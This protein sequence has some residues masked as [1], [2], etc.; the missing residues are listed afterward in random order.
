MQIQTWY[1]IQVISSICYLFKFCNNYLAGIRTTCQ[2]IVKLFSLKILL[3][4]F[5][6]SEMKNLFFFTLL[7]SYSALTGYGQGEN[8]SWRESYFVGEPLQIGNRVQF[9]FDDYVVEDKFG[10]KRVIGPVKKYSE[11]PLI[12]GKDMPWEL[13]TLNWEGP[14]LRH[15]IF[16]PKE[17]LYKSWYVMIRWE[18]GFETGYNY[19]TLYVESK[20]GITWEKPELDLFPYNGQKTNIVLQKEKGT[21]ILEEVILDT[22]AN[23][24]AHR[25]LGL[26]KMVP[27]GEAGR[28]IVRMFSPDGKKWTLAP[29]PILFRNASDGS[30]SLVNDSERSRWLLY[31]RP[32]IRALVNRKDEGFYTSRNVK[33]RVSVTLSKDMKH[34]TYPRNI[35]LM[36]EVDDSKVTQVGNNIDIDWAQVTRYEGIFFGFLSLMDNLI[37]SVPRHSHLMWSRDG[38]DWERLPER[39]F[40]IKNG[41]PGDWDAGSI[42]GISLIPEGDRIRIY[43]GG[44]NTTQGMENDAGIHPFT[45]TGIAYIGRDRFIGLQAGPEGGFLL[46]REFVLEGDRIKINCRSQVQNPPPI[47][48]SLIK[49]ELIQPPK[50]EHQSATPYP[51]YSMEDCDPI[52]A[53]DE[54]HQVIT[55]NGKSDLSSLNGKPIYIRFYIRNSTL[56]TFRVE[57]FY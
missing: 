19:S 11:N 34:W 36:D 26:V 33:R 30:Y 42:R 45:G 50:G 47:W 5:F 15:V 1:K 3:K 14:A 9:L 16:D 21:A 38:F 40:F 28:C 43:Y 10:L 2:I 39:P 48:G 56:Y 6:I 53:E 35:V 24:P 8:N 29:D 32:S 7:F 49:A 22:M 18:P 37:M 55:W 54:F 20:D 13:N 25:Y 17:N 46:T 4:V 23:D 51:G 41:K 57:N 12:I 27:P 31:R 44:G 52:M